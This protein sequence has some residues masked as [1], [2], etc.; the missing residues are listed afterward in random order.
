MLA[1]LLLSSHRL[2]HMTAAQDSAEQKNSCGEHVEAQ[3]CNPALKMPRCLAQ[4]PDI[5]WRGWCGI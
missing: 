2:C 4:F 5:V 3:P 1:Q